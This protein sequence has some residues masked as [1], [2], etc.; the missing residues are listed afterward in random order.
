[1]RLLFTTCLVLLLILIARL[2]IYS[3]DASEYAYVTRLGKP[4]GTFDGLDAETCL[5][6]AHEIAPDAVPSFEAWVRPERPG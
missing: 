1:M 3:V 6:W 5:A 4:A 2:S